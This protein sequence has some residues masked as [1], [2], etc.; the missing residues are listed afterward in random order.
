MSSEPQGKTRPRR[1]CVDVCTR[2]EVV[3]EFDA[4]EC[5]TERTVQ[6]RSERSV[7]RTRRTALVT[8]ESNTNIEGERERRL[9]LADF[10]K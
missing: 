7:M 3:H 1:T 8:C 5:R 6:E 10:G 9:A 2:K 4:K